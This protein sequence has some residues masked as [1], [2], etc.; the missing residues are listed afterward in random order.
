MEGER[1]DD[2]ATTPPCYMGALPPTRPSTGEK[3]SINP[4]LE[5]VD[6]YKRGQFVPGGRLLKFHISELEY[7]ELEEKLSEDLFFKAKISRD[8]FPSLRLFVLRMPSDIHERFL[9]RLH[10]ETRHQLRNL[11]GPSSSFA[12]EIEFIASTHLQSHKKR[13][14]VTE[15][16]YSQDNKKLPHLAD[17][18]ILGSNLRVRALLG[19]DIQ[20]QRK[21]A[22]VSVWR[23][24]AVQGDDREVWATAAETQVF[25]DDNGEPNLDTHAGLRVSLRDFASVE[26]CKKFENLKG[27]IFISCATLCTFLNEAEAK[28]D[29]ESESEPDLELEVHASSSEEELNTDDERDM[30]RA[31][32]HAEENA[33]RADPSFK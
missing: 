2:A 22:L 5:A 28:I 7:Q 6:R 21:K 29:D 20:Y 19:F 31:E 8:Y 33:G 24:H 30:V 32:K 13:V 26:F 23:P 15:V 17:E 4:I 14:W 12:Q 3:A 9:V 16:A 10:D 11:E 25:R 27:S 18:Y 1:Q